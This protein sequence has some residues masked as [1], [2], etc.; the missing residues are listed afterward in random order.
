MPRIKV[1]IQPTAFR[2]FCVFYD[3]GTSKS[4]GRM[5]TFQS[6]DKVIEMLLRAGV[7][8]EVRE[9]AIEAVGM[10]RPT[11]VDL[12]LTDGQIAKLMRG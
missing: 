8:A 5:R 4:V 10:N 9:A 12:D 6:I 3:P 2:Y 7:T 11:T 1:S